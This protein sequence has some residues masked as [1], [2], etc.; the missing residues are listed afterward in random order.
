MPK[1]S[2]RPFPY[3]KIRKKAMEYFAKNNSYDIFDFFKNF[4]IPFLIARFQWN[5]AF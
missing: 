1:R 3:L 4:H 2:N 5:S